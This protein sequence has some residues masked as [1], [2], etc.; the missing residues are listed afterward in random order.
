MNIMNEITSKRDSLY[1]K[2]KKSDSKD[3]NIYKEYMN[4]LKLID[5]I[6]ALIKLEIK[7][8][9][10]NMD[11]F[12]ELKNHVYEDNVFDPTYPYIFS[13]EFLRDEADKIMPKELIYKY[14]SDEIDKSN[15]FEIV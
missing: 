11:D 5:S 10:I 1:E 6:N 12:E 7:F 14:I 4:I 9:D 3:I 15:K 13:V 8:E 2:F